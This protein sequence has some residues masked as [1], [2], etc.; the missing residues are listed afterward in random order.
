M[1]E[2]PWPAVSWSSSSQLRVVIPANEVRFLQKPQGPRI[3]WEATRQ[4]KGG[5]H[6]SLGGQPTPQAQT[7]EEPAL[8]NR[9]FYKDE[10]ARDQ[11][12]QTVA[13]RSERGFEGLSVEVLR[14]Q[15]KADILTIGVGKMSR[16]WANR[17]LSPWIS[18]TEVKMAI[19]LWA[20]PASAV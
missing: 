14:R 1:K 5:L 18:S 4:M 17:C 19:W 9:D 7:P 2:F 10:N 11:G 13:K 15:G 6:R 12:I 8:R 16:H 3:A 20:D